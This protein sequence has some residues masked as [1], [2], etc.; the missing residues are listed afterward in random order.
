MKVVLVYGGWSCTAGYTHWAYVAEAV[1]PDKH[2]KGQYV[3][4]ISL[5]EISRIGRR[6]FEPP[7]RREIS[8]PK[9]CDYG[10]PPGEFPIKLCEHGAKLIGT[11]SLQGSK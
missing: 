9:C 7:N 6:L 10:R 2:H 5:Y 11:K 1:E 8:D 3:D 4:G